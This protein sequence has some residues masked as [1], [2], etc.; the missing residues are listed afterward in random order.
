MSTIGIDGTG[1]RAEPKPIPHNIVREIRVIDAILSAITT[2]FH[3]IN[4]FRFSFAIAAVLCLFYSI[5]LPTLFYRATGKVL[6]SDASVYYFLSAIG[7][8]LT[9]RALKDFDKRSRLDQ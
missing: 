5:A 1:R 8:F 3:P 2:F 6:L 4:L 7:M 9:E